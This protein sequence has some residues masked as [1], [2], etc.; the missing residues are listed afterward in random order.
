MCGNGHTG[1]IEVGKVIKFP[2]RRHV[3]ASSNGYRSGRKSCRDTPEIC[4]TASTR[5]GG[6]SSHC[7]TACIEIP[8]GSARPDKP[9]TASIAR[10][11]ASLGSVMRDRSSTALPESQA[12]LHCDNK[13]VLYHIGMSIGKRIRIARERLGIGQ[14]TLG[15]AV[16]VTKQAVY[17]WEVKNKEPK[18][19]KLPELRKVLRVTFAWLLAGDGPPPDPESPEVR[20]DDW[21]VTAFQK[22][23]R[24]TA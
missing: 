21:M 15:D 1:A 19:D 6:T 20:M 9:P 3:R 5:N 10:F 4:S 8:R 13:A 2:R 23:P 18:Q 22:K 14:E 7:E 16:G 24:N 11:K 17:E 12:L